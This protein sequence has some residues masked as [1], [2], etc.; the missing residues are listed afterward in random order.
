MKSLTATN[1]PEYEV[2]GLNIT[3]YLGRMKMLLIVMNTDNDREKEM[4]NGLLL[5]VTMCCP[6][7]VNISLTIRVVVVIAIIWN[8]AR[9]Y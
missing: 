8:D 2:T 4:N 9:E 3:D 5:P 6:S 7:F 1:N